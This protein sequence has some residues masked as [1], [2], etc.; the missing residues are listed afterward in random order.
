MLSF[1]R[2]M[3]TVLI[4]RDTCLPIS[5]TFIKAQAESLTRYSARFGGIYPANPSLPLGDNVALL[6]REA[7]WRSSLRLVLYNKLNIA[8]DFF[9]LVRNWDVSL[10][11][12][13]FAPDGLRAIRLSKSLKVPLIVTLHGYDVTISD[14]FKRDYR[15][16]W[17][18]ADVFLCV[19]NFIRRCAIERGFPEEKLLVHYI[20]VDESKFRPGAERDSSSSKNVLFVGRLVEKK[21]CQYL[22]AAMRDVQS[23]VPEAT[24]TIIGDGPLRLDL[25]N[26]ARRLGVVCEFLGAQDPITISQHMKQAAVFCVPSVTSKDGDSEGFGIVFIEAQASGIPV[27]SFRHGG[28]PE[29]VQDGMTGLLAPE[30]DVAQLARNIIRYLCDD[31]LR[32]AAGRAA[33]EFVRKN[34]ALVDQTAKLESIYDWVLDAKGNQGE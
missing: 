8:P 28:I 2:A 11:H 5:E 26:Q 22:I 18:T 6:V 24:L 14:V 12:A 33:R 21:G 30:R 25:E 1:C 9:A 32:L 4:Y 23:A 29:A 13:H 17:Q 16:L 20:G 19:S 10:I 27:V 31:D 15:E 3:T 34:Y 7:G